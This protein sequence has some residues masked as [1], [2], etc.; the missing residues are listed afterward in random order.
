MYF[1]HQHIFSMYIFLNVDDSWQH[2]EA[3]HAI[4]HW[5]C[6]H[7]CTM[8]VAWN[9]WVGNQSRAQ[10]HPYGKC[11]RRCCQLHS[12][13]YRVNIHHTICPNRSI[14]YKY[15]RGK[16]QGFNLG[17]HGKYNFEVKLPKARIIIKH[18]TIL[19]LVFLC[20]APPTIHPI[21]VGVSRRTK[22]FQPTM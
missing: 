18:V 16:S 6:Q 22:Y 2:C 12:S 3:R 8:S 10:K 11:W 1:F 5:Y 14:P 4:G 21:I 9:W 15:Y 19:T 13:G 17:G 7:S 20:T